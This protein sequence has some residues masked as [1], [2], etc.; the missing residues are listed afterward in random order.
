MHHPE[1]H[2]MFFNWYTDEWWLANSSCMAEAEN[3]K[4]IIKRSII[5]DH[6]P[7]IE[8]DRESDLNIGNIV[9]L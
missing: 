6:Y 2:W 4:G 3:L 8:K 1:Y 7:R 5:L 9:S